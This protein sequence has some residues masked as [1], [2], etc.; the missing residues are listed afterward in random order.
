MN[1]HGYIDI[2]AEA[3]ERVKALA[4][5]IVSASRATDIP[6]FFSAWFFDR[7][8]KGYCVWKNPYNSK[9]SYVSFANT[10]FIVFWSKIRTDV[11]LVGPTQR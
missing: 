11:T 3:G 1:R 9:K 10:R 8:E 4:P 6:A 2:T 7:L 5:I